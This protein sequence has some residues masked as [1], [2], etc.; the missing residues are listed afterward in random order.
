MVLLSTQSL[1]HAIWLL[2]VNSVNISHNL[3]MD[4]PESVLKILIIMNQFA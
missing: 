3:Q 4:V 1:E 2:N